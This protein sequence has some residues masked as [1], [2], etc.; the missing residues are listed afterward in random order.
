MTFSGNTTQS[1]IVLQIALS[2]LHK[3]NTEY[4]DGNIVIES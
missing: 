3:K 2:V 1:N 4:E